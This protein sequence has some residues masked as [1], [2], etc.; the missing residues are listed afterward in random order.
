MWFLLL[1]LQHIFKRNIVLFGL[2]WLFYLKS[3]LQAHIDEMEEFKWYHYAISVLRFSSCFILVLLLVVVNYAL[4]YLVWTFKVLIE[5]IYLWH[6]YPNFD[7]KNPLAL[8]LANFWREM[9]HHWSCGIFL[10]K[11]HLLKKN[12]IS[13]TKQLQHG[14]TNVVMVLLVACNVSHCKRICRKVIVLAFM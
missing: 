12:P 8:V 7:F 3:D 14:Q 6:I 10:L 2:N 5:Y 4:Q 11:A 9:F 1:L 13:T